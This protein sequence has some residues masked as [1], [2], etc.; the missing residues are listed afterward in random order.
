MNLHTAM[1]KL[2]RADRV[3]RKVVNGYTDVLSTF[4]NVWHQVPLLS[5]RSLF[6]WFVIIYYAGLFF[7]LVQSF[8]D[9]GKYYRPTLLLH[10]NGLV[11][12]ALIAMFHK[13][14]SHLICVDNVCLTHSESRVAI[15]V[16]VLPTLVGVFIFLSLFIRNLRRRKAM[17]RLR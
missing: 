12:A 7:F 3:I 8:R 1:S 15:S 13:Y 14:L 6:Y 10:L 4:V 17:N 16:I 11:I 5:P 9:F 2:E